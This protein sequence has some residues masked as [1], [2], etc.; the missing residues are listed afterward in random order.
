MFA[1]TALRCASDY[2]AK[3]SHLIKPS[4]D[5]PV[6]QPGFYA[7]AVDRGAVNSNC[8]ISFPKVRTEL[9]GFEPVILLFV[10]HC[11]N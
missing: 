3:S 2:E 7:W 6:Y 11:M 8:P 1:K 4:M 9:S 10:R 5:A